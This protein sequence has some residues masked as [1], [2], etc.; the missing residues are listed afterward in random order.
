MFY[1]RG[2]LKKRCFVNNLRVHCG[3]NWHIDTHRCPTNTACSTSHLLYASQFRREPIQKEI[4]KKPNL[5]TNS[6][7]ALN[8]TSSPPWRPHP[9]GKRHQHQSAPT[10]TDSPLPN[11]AQSRSVVQ[12][13]TQT[14]SNSLRITSIFILPPPPSAPPPSHQLHYGQ[15]F[16]L[17]RPPPGWLPCQRQ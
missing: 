16:P 2:A 17:G 12:K 15:R 5:D 11:A 9:S 8:A 13:R 10:P 14:T 7:A 4:V 6:H 3:G 1:T